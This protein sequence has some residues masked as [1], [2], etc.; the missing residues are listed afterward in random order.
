MIA[1]Q[2]NITLLKVPIQIDNIN[3]LTF[4]NSQNQFNYFNSLSKLTY[5]KCTYQRKDNVIRFE[6]NPDSIDGLSYEDLLEYNYC[7]Y[8]NEKYSNKWFYAFITDITYQNDGRTDLTIKTDVWQTWCFDIQ[9]KMSFVEREIIKKSDDVVGA[10]T[11]PENLETGEYLVNGTYTDSNLND[12]FSDLRYVIGCSV[13]LENPISEGGEIKRFP[14]AGGGKYNGVYSGVKYWAY[15]LVDGQSAINTFLK[16][17]ETVGQADTITGLFLA[18]KFVVPTVQEQGVVAQSDSPQSYNL[19]V[20]KNYGLGGYVPKNN[21]VRTYPYCYLVGTNNQGESNIYHYEKFS[22]SNCSFDVK[23][24][25]S[26]GTSIRMT[27]LNYNGASIND[28]EGINLGKFPICNYSVDM[29]TNWLSQNSINVAGR[30]IT[31]DQLNMATTYQSGFNSIVDSLTSGSVG[32]FINNVFGTGVSIAQNLIQQKQHSL[33]PPSVNGNINNGDVMTAS[34]KNNFKFYFMSVKREF[35]EKIDS[36]F[37]IYG[38]AINQYK[39]PELYSRNN[40]NYIKT[41]GLNIIGDIPQGD[42]QEIKS[43]FNN[44]ITLWH[45]PSTFLDY[46]QSND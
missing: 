33:I 3:Q 38:Y 36:Y 30:T 35:A 17:L 41:N 32:G 28:S 42:M 1:P 23:G 20:S 45:N 25:L 46:S 43:L 6:T 37:S 14:I 34:N 24:V 13:D 2:T 27:P 44:G 26:P 29:Y 4:S 16:I 19:S 31:T 18:P 40:W 12:R 9:Y 5:D 22:G 7:M 11:Y 8:Q 21:K 39:I 10:Y 15:N